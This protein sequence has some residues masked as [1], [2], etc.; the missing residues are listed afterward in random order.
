M[1]VMKFGG[2]SLESAAAIQQVADIVKQHLKQNPVVVVSAM[3]KTTDCLLDAAQAAARGD[4][5]T[6]LQQVQNLRRMHIATVRELL[7]GR[8]D[9]FL[10]A[11]RPCSASYRCCWWI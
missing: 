4:S 9:A 3:G 5:Y 8:T 1:I 6:A 7:D 10:A 11:F 2:S